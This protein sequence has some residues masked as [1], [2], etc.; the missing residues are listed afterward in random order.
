MMRRGGGGGGE[1]KEEE[2]TTSDEHNA[3]GE[4]RSS[5]GKIHV[6]FISSRKYIAEGTIMHA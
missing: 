4:E 6:V 5:Q 1:E 3:M 2:Y